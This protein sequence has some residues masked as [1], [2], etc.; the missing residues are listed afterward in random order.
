MSFIFYETM[1]YHQITPATARLMLRRIEEQSDTKIWGKFENFLCD[2]PRGVSQPVLLLFFSGRIKGGG[3]SESSHC[4][5]QQSASLLLPTAATS[6]FLTLSLGSLLF[7][8]SL[9]LNFSF[10]FFFHRLIRPA[11]LCPSHC[12]LNSRLALQCVS[13][14]CAYWSR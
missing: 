12:S 8:T 5:F 1:K 14:I 13:T 9:L 3:C 11:Q 6:R 2:S 7:S 10:F 4:V